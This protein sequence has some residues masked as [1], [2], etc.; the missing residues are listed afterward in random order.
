M[1]RRPRFGI[2][3]R[4]LSE[5]RHLRLL[6]LRCWLTDSC[7]CRDHDRLATSV[8]RLARCSRTISRAARLSDQP[9]GPD[10]LLL[11]SAVRWRLSRRLHMTT[12]LQGAA[13]SLPRA[14]RSRYRTR[15]CG[16][17]LVKYMPITAT[18]DGGGRGVP[19]AALKVPFEVYVPGRIAGP[20]RPDLD[21]ARRPV[22]SRRSLQRL[23]SVRFPQTVFGPPPSTCL[24]TQGGSSG[25]GCRSSAVLAACGRHQPARPSPMLDPAARAGWAS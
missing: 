14:C 13:L 8:R 22:H 21:Q 17:R 2:S 6:A 18:R 16:D 5:C 10:L 9:S 7:I 19:G 3:I 23:Y 11:V 20:S 24:I 4:Y 12:R 25:C 15:A 1:A